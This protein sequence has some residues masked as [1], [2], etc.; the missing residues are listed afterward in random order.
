MIFRRTGFIII[1]V[2]AFGCSTKK[3][4]W[5]SRN[6]H[7]LTAY[8]NVYFNGKEA[9]NNGV[10]AIREGYQNDYSA[11]LPMFESSDPDAIGVASG[12]MDRA[13]EKGTKLIK[14]HSMTAKPKKRSGSKNSR[15]AEFYSKNEY[16]QWVD[17]A[18]LLIGKAQFYKHEFLPAIRT[19]QYVIR[20]FNNTPA[21]Y[22]GLIWLARTYTEY[23]DYIGALSALESYDLGGDAPVELYGDFMATYANL[24]LKQEK[25]NDAIPYLRNNIASNKDR[26]QTI[27][28]TFIL[29][30]IY[31]DAN[32]REEAVEAFSYVAKASPD[33]EMTFN[34]KVNKASIIYADAD[35]EEVKKQLHKLR[36][37]KKNKDY[38]DRIYWA[39]GQVAEQ[40]GNY[41]EALTYY[42]KSVETSVSN[43]EQKGRSYRNA[44]EIYYNRL[45]YPNAYFYYDSALTVLN[46]EFETYDELVERHSG[47]SGLV[48]NILIVQRED[49]LQRLADMS[50]PVLLAYLDNIIEQKKEEELLAKKK[51]EEDNFNDPFF[52]QNTGSN[53]SVNQTGGKWYF[54]NQTSKSLGQME[55]QKRWGK[56]KLE[57]N[58]RR[59]DKS[60]NFEEESDSNDPFGLPDNPFVENRNGEE[61]KGEAGEKDKTESQPAGTTSGVPTRE[62]LMADIPLSEEQ[63][64][65]SDERTETALME[66]GLLFM[67]RLANYP[68]SIESLED[69]LSR[70]P[71]GKMR[72]QAMVALYNAYR[73]NGDQSGMASTKRRLET[74]FPESR[75]VAYLNDPDFFNKLDQ[76]RKDREEAYEKTYEDFLFGRFSDVITQSSSVIGNEDENPLVPKYFLLRALSNGKTGNIDGFK[77][78]LDELIAQSPDTKEAALAQELLKHLE[79]GKTPVQGTLYSATPASGITSKDITLTEG[80]TGLDIETK[81]FVFVENEPY[82]L[83]VMQIEPSKV[84]RAVYN[85]ADYNFSRYLLHD[86]EIKEQVLINGDNA[87]IVSG[88]R[89]KNEAMDYFYSLRERPEFFQFD[90][91]KD[92]I[93]VISQSNQNKFYLS[94]LINEYI[95]FFNTYYLTPIAKA[96][97][98]KVRKVQEE[99]EEP[100]DTEEENAVPEETVAETAVNPINQTEATAVKEEN[101]TEEKAAESTGTG[102]TVS[103][104][105]VTA[106]DNQKTDVDEEVAPKAEEQKEFSPYQ[107][108]LSSPHSVLVI[109]QKTR[110]DYKRL[111][112]IYTNYTHNKFGDEIKVSMIDIGDNYRAI[113]IDGF[114]NADEAK[115][116]TNDIKTNQFLTR[117]INRKE[118]YFWEISAKNLET[119]LNKAELKSYEEFYK[120][121]Y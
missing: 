105:A 75:F 61:Q 28:F 46:E 49:S 63:R 69:L 47:L 36:K 5:L 107:P 94:G 19:F 34:A 90:Y 115:V 26:K 42:K 8:Y 96:E 18:Y 66:M 15:S 116:Y 33:Y 54:Y 86:F 29:G 20:E 51:E 89:N 79:E 106:L 35:I 98:D 101:I 111:Q 91:F 120:A 108:D 1:L 74:E 109:V 64:M 59:S 81:E 45:D 55:F 2:V 32:R 22:E 30:Q 16:N 9:L 39:F 119:L 72:D 104:A 92:N 31:K 21:Q 38:L 13:I 41:D 17:N 77:N 56:R 87:I 14:K 48:E 83:V 70:Y 3:N 43:D 11:I 114:S 4:T 80:D 112:T 103:T 27:R 62:E 25:Y 88:F 44:G 65:A 50:E 52:Y 100:I 6:Y 95:E 121:N 85:V 24:L 68:K 78:D 7:N 102:E 113:Q 73:L 53:S 58:W 57:D 40:E 99:P 60:K 23:K 76:I 97:L 110:M 12:D 117:D 82:D 37:D 118:H 71:D 84:N 67:D 93:V 10:K